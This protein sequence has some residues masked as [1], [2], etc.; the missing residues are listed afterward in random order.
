[1]VV[2]LQIEQPLSMATLT[3]LSLPARIATVSDNFNPV[4]FLNGHTCLLVIEAQYQ[5]VYPPGSI[6][7]R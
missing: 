7:K 1:M 4:H 2:F 6:S 5:K 3:S